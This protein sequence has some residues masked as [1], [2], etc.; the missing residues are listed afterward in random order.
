MFYYL[1][2]I[3]NNL[4]GKIY[5][6]VHKTKDMNDGYM[7][8]G[9]IIRSAIGKHGIANFSKV[10]LETFDNAESMYAREAEVVT[11]EFLL[12]EDVYNIR[13]GGH[14]G[15]DHINKNEELRIAKNKKSREKSDE[16]MSNELGENWR[17]IIGQL[18]GQNARTDEAKNKRKLTREAN[19]TKSD[20]SPMNTKQANEKRLVAFRLNGHQQ[21]EKNS[22]FGT[23]WICNLELRENKKIKSNEQIPEGWI[24]GRKMFK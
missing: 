4:N 14:G 16:T 11:D 20:A 17:K 21:G 3:R 8:S 5:V 13:R 24:K 10:I 19:G 15:F 6:G 2:E 12:R 23:M 1:Y 7:G 22:Q 9:K 18:G